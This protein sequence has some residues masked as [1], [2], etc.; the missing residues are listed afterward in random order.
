V[1]VVLLYC[2]VFVIS[3]LIAY[4]IHLCCVKISY[5]LVGHTHEDIDAIIG[6]VITYLRSKNIPTLTDFAEKV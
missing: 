3:M 1:K 2:V 5:C 6:N 4:L